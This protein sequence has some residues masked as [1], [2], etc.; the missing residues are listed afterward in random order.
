ML[1]FCVF[2]KCSAMNTC[3]FQNQEKSEYCWCVYICMYRCSHIYLPVP[4]SC[5]VSCKARGLYVPLLAPPSV[6]TSQPLLY[7]LRLLVVPLLTSIFIC[8]FSIESATNMLK[9]FSSKKTNIL[10]PCRHTKSYPSCALLPSFL[11]S[12]HS[13]K[14]DLPLSF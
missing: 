8:S 7:Q 3:Y 9:F 11:A 2:S 13:P 4:T 10:P 1:L 6:L 5:L 14:S 12:Y